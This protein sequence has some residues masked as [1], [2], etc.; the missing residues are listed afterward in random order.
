MTKH[1]ALEN[2]LKNKDKE[3]ASYKERGK[4]AEKEFKEVTKSL[5]EYRI[6]FAV[7]KKNNEDLKAQLAICQKNCVDKVKKEAEA[8]SKLSNQ[9]N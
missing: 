7:E 5:E 8:K 3:I 9:N 1:T 2:D 4:E 6:N